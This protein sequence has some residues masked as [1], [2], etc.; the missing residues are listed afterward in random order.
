MDF[1]THLPLTIKG[2]TN[3]LVITCRFTG[4]VILIPLPDLT[5]DTITQVFLTRV[6]VYHGPPDWIVSDRGSQWVDG[7]WKRFCEL[8]GITRKLSTSYHP[9]T[10]GSTERV[11]QEVQ[12][13]LR[14][15]ITY[16]QSDWD[17][18]LPAAQVALNNRP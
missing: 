11:N 7:F 3:L 14:A 12:A 2:N 17:N 15:Y 5:V 1:M 10:D 6:Y 8:M 9:E 18:W 16:D 4:Y 13:F